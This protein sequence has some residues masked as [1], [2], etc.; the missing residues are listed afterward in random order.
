MSP[1]P[2][3]ANPPVEIDPT[4]EAIERVLALRP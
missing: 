2:Q 3:Y 1:A 4:V